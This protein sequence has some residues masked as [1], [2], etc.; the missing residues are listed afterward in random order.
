MTAICEAFMGACG[1]EGGDRA[2][3]APKRWDESSSPGRLSRAPRAVDFSGLRRFVNG[4]WEDFGSWMGT[5]EE[6]VAWVVGISVVTFVGSLVA[7]PIVVIQMRSD[8]FLRTAEV[9]RPRTPLQLI[10]RILK[11][12]LGLILLI[13]GFAMLFLP[14]QGLLAMLL[15]MSLLDFPG[16]RNLQLRL[17]KLKGVQRSVNWMRRKADKPPLTLP[18]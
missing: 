10:R 2:D 7:V 5:W 13:M 6:E 1:E 4:M 12:L 17:L 14:G 18:E 9:K 16:K 3:T 8:Y 15:G 11:N